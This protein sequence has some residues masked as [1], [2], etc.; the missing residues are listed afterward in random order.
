MDRR[1]FF[2]TLTSL[3][4]GAVAWL[5]FP[6]NAKNWFATQVPRWRNYSFTYNVPTLWMVKTSHGNKNSGV[7]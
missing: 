5:A 1:G 7:V 6:A 3:M 4:A 2:A